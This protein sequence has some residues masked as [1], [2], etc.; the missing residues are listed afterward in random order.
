M[1]FEHNLAGGVMF[2]L[3][4][5][6]LISAATISNALAWGDRGHSIVA[7]LAERRLEPVVRQKIEALLGP[8]ISMASIASWADAVRLLRPETSNWHF[9]DIPVGATAYVPAEHCKPSP[10]GDC[11]VAALGRLRDALVDTNQ[12]QTI[13]REA[14]MFIV[15]FIGDLHQPL[16]AAERNNDEG[17]NKVRVIWLDR[18]HLPVV[19]NLHRYWD[20]GAIER[21]VF[22]L[23]RVRRE[24]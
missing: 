14:L 18:D 7:E 13:R 6:L 19:S 21:K 17:G 8:G 11:V 4:L 15:H 23:G 2:R 16:H 12:S 20:F 24:P 22:D 5:G 10:K 9:V 1:L 3:V